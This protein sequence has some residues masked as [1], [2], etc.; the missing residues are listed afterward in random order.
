MSCVCF[1]QQKTNEIVYVPDQ[2]KLLE[3]QSL[4]IPLNFQLD[5]SSTKG[6]EQE[7]D[8]FSDFGSLTSSDFTF[9]TDENST[10]K[11]KI[12]TNTHNF[13]Q[14]QKLKCLNEDL[15]S[16][17]QQ[18]KETEIKFFREIQQGLDQNIK[19]DNI[20]KRRKEYLQKVYGKNIKMENLY[21]P[22][23]IKRILLRR[24][25]SQKNFNHF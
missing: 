16:I 14:H 13:K 15:Y 24:K 9:P 4:D 6:N 5:T 7:N 10:R 23:Q 21:S 12:N 18:H 11:E 19:V 22:H 17:I 3:L 2:L 8:N 20:L 25:I 1:P